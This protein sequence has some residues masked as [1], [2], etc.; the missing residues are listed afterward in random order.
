MFCKINKNLFRNPPM[1]CTDD[2]DYLGIPNV[3]LSQWKSKPPSGG[4]HSPG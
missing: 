3:D 1:S 2:L 4:K